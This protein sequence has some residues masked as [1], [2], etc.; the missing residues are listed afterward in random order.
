MKTALQ[1]YEAVTRK[2]LWISAALLVLGILIYALW[3]GVGAVIAVIGFG[4]LV[5][6]F[7]RR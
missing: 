2:M 6:C 7:L 5:W 1:E 3:F 4:G